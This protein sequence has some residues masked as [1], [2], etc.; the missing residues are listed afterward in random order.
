MTMATDE[1]VVLDGNAIA[2]LLGELFGGSEMTAAL[3]G[4]GSCG[5][6]HAI[7]EH[8]LYHGAGLVLRCPGCGDVALVVVERKARREVQ[9]VGRWSV[10]AG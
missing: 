6:S 4:C 8:R 9:L 10:A 3:R 1:P 5:Q 7:G 2:G